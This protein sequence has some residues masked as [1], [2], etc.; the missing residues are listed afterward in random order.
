[1]NW[2]LL[3]L[4]AALCWGIEALLVDWAGLHIDPLLGTGIGC[5][6]AGLISLLYILATGGVQSVMTAP[7]L[8]TVIFA[9][10]GILAFAIGHGVYY[11]AINADRVSRVVPIV[12][13]YPLIAI[14][15]AALILHESITLRSAI[16]A[17][18]VFGGVVLITV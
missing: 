4:L 11:M 15:L 5:I 12:A 1:M 8:P 14:L 10:A 16:G 6:A 2:I 17:L 7:P 9:V 18:L 3:S 13:S